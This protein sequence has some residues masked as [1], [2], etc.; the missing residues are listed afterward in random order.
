M[1]LHPAWSAVLCNCPTEKQRATQNC[2]PHESSSRV[3]FTPQSARIWP[4]HVASSFIIS[5][6]EKRWWSSRNYVSLG[7]MPLRWHSD[8]QN[9]F[10][11]VLITSR[12]EEL[13]VVLCVFMKI[14]RRWEKACVLPQPQRFYFFHRYSSLCIR[15]N[16]PFSRGTQ[17]VH[18]G[19]ADRVAI[20]WQARDMSITLWPNGQ[21]SASFLETKVPC[22]LGWTDNEGTWLNCDCFIWVYRLLWLFELVL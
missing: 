8:M 4:C 15:I 13:C 5:L 2:Q 17:S 9:C 20:F 11:Q 10:S 12:K 3:V 22:T 16:C 19:A 7:Q 14:H 6:Q 18:A 21:Q 1:A